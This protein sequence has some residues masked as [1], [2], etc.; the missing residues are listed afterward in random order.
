MEKLASY[1][2]KVEKRWVKFIVSAHVLERI[3]QV[4]RTTSTTLSNKIIARIKRL[5]KPGMGLFSFH[6][7][8]RTRKGS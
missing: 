8:W 4:A 2:D 3:S 6:T 1:A 5:V 7:A